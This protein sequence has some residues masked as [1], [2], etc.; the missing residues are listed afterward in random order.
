MFFFGLRIFSCRSSD[1]ITI[2]SIGENLF[3][4]GNSVWYGVR[5]YYLSSSGLSCTKLSCSSG[6]G[7][8]DY[9]LI[10]MGR[11]YPKSILALITYR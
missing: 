2:S 9:I 5:R 1:G 6:L 8:A 11:R 10:H 7:C 3:R 4:V